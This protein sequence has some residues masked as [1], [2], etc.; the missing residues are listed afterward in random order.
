MV[1]ILSRTQHPP[2]NPG[3]FTMFSG[4]ASRADGMIIPYSIR[5]ASL[6]HIGHM[7]VAAR[8]VFDFGPEVVS[9]G[10]MEAL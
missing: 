3:R 7:R 4:I 6:P 8:F 9:S 10:V 5:Q 1:L 2:L